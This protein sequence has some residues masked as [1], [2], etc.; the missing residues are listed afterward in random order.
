[1]T[2]I[3]KALCR[4]CADMLA[5]SLPA[6]WYTTSSKVS[7][8]LSTLMNIQEN[9]VKHFQLVQWLAD[10]GQQGSADC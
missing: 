6:Y 2:L 1:M 10:D 5:A 8:M 7:V 3:F 9:T 4:P